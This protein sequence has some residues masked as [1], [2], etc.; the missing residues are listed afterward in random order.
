MGWGGWRVKR[1]RLALLAVANARSDGCCRIESSGLREPP[2]A[3]QTG[4]DVRFEFLAVFE[5]NICG[6]QG[7]DLQ[8]QRVPIASETMGH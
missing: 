2:V 7:V 5:A 3:H 6:K 4:P 1:G 8:L